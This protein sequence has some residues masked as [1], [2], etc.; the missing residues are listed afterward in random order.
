MALPPPDRDAPIICSAIAQLHTLEFVYDGKPRVVEPYCHGT[1]TKGLE[2]VRAIQVGG[3]GS[4][5]GFGK[6]WTIGK[7]VGLRMTERTFVPDD[8]NYNPDD[9][10]FV[11]IH[12]RVEPAVRRAPLR[13]VAGG[14]SR[15]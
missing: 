10:A 11:R 2:Q 8:P 9:T 4:G 5:F 15:R 14:R 3:Q 12:C 7:M 6:Q 13:L 1:S